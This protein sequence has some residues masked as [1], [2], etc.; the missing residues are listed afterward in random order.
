MQLLYIYY[1]KSMILNW[2][3]NQGHRFIKRQNEQQKI[4]TQM[5]NKIDWFFFRWCKDL[6]SAWFCIQNID[7][8]RPFAINTFNTLIFFFTS[9]YNEQRR[10]YSLS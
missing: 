3:V 5:Q 8:S 10:L 7:F 9:N 6:F 2:C 4:N 1:L